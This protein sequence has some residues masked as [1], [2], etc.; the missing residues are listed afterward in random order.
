MKSI[1]HGDMGA[2]SVLGASD[3]SGKGTVQHDQLGLGA[4]NEA[5]A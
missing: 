4:V 3:E 1:A 5:T 2:S